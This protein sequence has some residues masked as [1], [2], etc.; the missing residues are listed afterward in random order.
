MKRKAWF[1]ILAILILAAVL[2]AAAAE[3]VNPGGIRSGDW[4][5][6]KKGDAAVLIQY[7]GSEQDLSIPDHIDGLPVAIIG[8]ENGIRGEIF[9]DENRDIIRS[10]RIPETVLK[11]NRDAF[12]RCSSLE[13]VNIPAHIMTIE[14]G[15]FERTALKHIELPESLWKIGPYAFRDTPLEEIHIPSSVKWI[16]DRAFE[17]CTQLKE[18]EWPGGDVFIG[19]DA[20]MRT[21]IPEGKFSL[22]EQY[23][24]YTNRYRFY[25]PDDACGS[26]QPADYLRIEYVRKPDGTAGILGTY[27]WEG[28]PSALTL[29]A[30]IEGMPVT[31]YYGDLEDN[32]S[33]LE[34]LVLP[35]SMTEIGDMA[36]NHLEIKT[37]KLPGKL[38]RIGHEA[39]Q[40]CRNLKDVKLPPSLLEIGVG[41]FQNS[42]ADS[43][44]LKESLDSQVYALGIRRTGTHQLGSIG[45]Y[46]DYSVNI[47]GML[48]AL[49]T[50]YG[51]ED[52]K[53]LLLDTDPECRVRE[54]PE[55]YM[56]F[57]FEAYPGDSLRI[58]NGIAYLLSGDGKYLI[59]TQVTDPDGW[60]WSFPDETDGLPVKTEEY[61]TVRIMTDGCLC[62]LAE[63]DGKKGIRILQADTAK[64]DGVIPETI[65]SYSVYWLSEDVTFSEGGLVYR[66]CPHR[67][68]SVSLAGC[69][70]QEERIAV[71]ADVRGWKVYSVARGAFR[72]LP[73]LKSVFISGA[74]KEITE[75]AFEDCGALTEIEAENAEIYIANGA[76][77]GI[78]TKWP[79]VN[80]KC[81]SSA[82]P[83]GDGHYALFSD[84]TAEVLNWTITGGKVTIPEEIDGHPV[85]SIAGNAFRD[86][87][88]SS[89]SLPD[90][91]VRI[92]EEAFYGCSDLSSVRLPAALEYIGDFAFTACEKLGKIELPDSLTYMG[93][94]AFSSAGLT[95]VS[96]PGSLESVPESAFMN[97]D[98]LRSVSLPEGIK[99][100]GE[101]AFS[102]CKAL[103]SV[104]LPEGIK[105][106]G[107][108]AFYQCRALGSVSLPESLETI[109]A[110]CFQDDSLKKITIPA[111]VRSIGDNCFSKYGE[112]EGWGSLYYAGPEVVF[113]GDPEVSDKLFG[114]L[115]SSPDYSYTE[116]WDR[117]ELFIGHRIVKLKI[118]TSPGTVVDRTF[119]S[120][121]VVDK[122]YP[123]EKDMTAGETAAKETLE[124]ED[125]P[126]GIQILT[127]PE[128]VKKIAP[129]A[130][131]GI[132]TLYRVI[133]P[134][135]LLEIGESAFK[136]CGGLQ[137]VSI[138]SGL[139]TIGREAFGGCRNLKEI[140]LP[141][142]I[143]EIPEYCFLKD[144][145]LKTV[146]L[147]AGLTAIRDNAFNGC[148]Y[149]EEADFSACTALETIGETAFRRS[150]LKKIILPDS[151]KSLGKGAFAYP[152]GMN[153]LVL[154]KGLEEIPDEC[155]Y[156]CN[157]L[158]SLEIPGNIRRIGKEA[159]YQA[160]DMNSL[161][162]PEGLE[163][164]GEGAFRTFIDNVLVYNSHGRRYSSLKKLEIP[165]SLRTLGSGAFAGCDAMT[166]V[167]FR[168]PCSLEEIP[169]MCFA[170]CTYLKEI[171]IPGSIL[172]IGENAF[173]YCSA[174]T[175]AILEEGTAETGSEVFR[176]CEKLKQ[177]DLPASLTTIG[178][179]FLDGKGSG[180]TVTVTEGSEAEKHI[181]GY[182]PD[183]KIKHRK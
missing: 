45:T 129:E 86:K 175:K 172:R 149:L 70:L 58:R 6:L 88:F 28:A 143:R 75:G 171:R 183:A 47:D 5:Y 98:R 97:C 44:A 148:C 142:G 130:F 87:K 40:Y 74:T 182:Y 112:N 169:D 31:G 161:K 53:L 49:L 104:K 62:E 134:D 128:G 39:L 177:L 22:P 135:S 25:A 170:L 90:T 122:K 27:V 99:T 12:S 131:E 81:Y 145:N 167:T 76:F 34:A 11:I 132:N 9:T 137:Y 139:E 30:E 138:G 111:G 176:D 152:V 2:C 59:P 125:I 32:T 157:H 61:R 41:A 77:S 24:E 120:P 91:V 78:G 140:S 33:G 4:I 66:G 163:S 121:L 15:T 64:W 119:L 127:V 136:N 21:G 168:E 57:P 96:L 166:A 82:V 67:E 35:D 1:C 110:G 123:A 60:D 117:V 42:G 115:D 51:T 50:N 107:D 18:I 178:N 141:D 180:V 118:T 93:K 101:N 146:R 84:G 89:V 8:E 14:P 46:Y 174:L 68:K 17:G 71:P 92:G 181:A 13:E 26:F 79:E 155:F 159:F 103:S 150:A 23:A 10:V 20:F 116:F 85:I 165:S 72:Q 158:K 69:E 63:E 65:G 38:E 153:V 160:R 133:L 55:S 19:R 73:N 162:L 109:G 16:E 80:G 48:C 83:Q 3:D 105:T 173:R 156:H 106:I 113:E 56:G 29:P 52:P 126:Q 154:S 36:L 151:V 100:I 124:K 102:N 147:P 54:S 144:I 108:Y 7:T 37:L 164:I 114:L 179:M 94:W 43:A 95:S